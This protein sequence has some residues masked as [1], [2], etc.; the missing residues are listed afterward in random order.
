MMAERF[1]PDPFSP[2]PGARMYRTGD[3]ARWRSDGQHDFLGRIDH[4][5]KLRSYRIELGEIES[6]LHELT[7]GDDGR[8]TPKE[9]VLAAQAGD[10]AVRLALVRAFEYLGI[11]VANVVTCLHPDLVVLGGRMAG[12]GPLLFETVERV[13]HT[14]V[15][16]FPPDNVRIRPS[17]LGEKAGLSGGIAL[18]MRGGNV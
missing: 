10:E 5:V 13:M 17:L 14:R 12:A 6:A 15:G 4:Q 16:M 9:M 18:A 11:G 2:E 3:L 8:I 1:V 7:G